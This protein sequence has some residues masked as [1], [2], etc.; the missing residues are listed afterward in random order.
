MDQDK[1]PSTT[2]N[3]NAM[4]SAS[5]NRV[6]RHILLVVIPLA[7]VAVAGYWYWHGGRFVETD[8]AYVK[9]DVIPISAEISA[10]IVDVLVKENQYVSAGDVLFELRSAPY[11]FAVDE[12]AANVQEKKTELL[13]LQAS[14]REKEGQI[15]LADRNYEFAQK[16]L[17]RQRD[18]KG[19]NFV[20]ES[21]LDDLEH[22]VEVARQELQVLRLDLQRIAASL[23]G[24]VDAPLDQHPSYLSA[25]AKLKQY[26]LSLS[27]T[28]VQAPVDGIVSQLPMVGQYVHTGNTVAALVATESLWVEANYSEVDLTHVRPGQKVDVKIDTYP[29]YHWQGVVESISPAT[30]AEFAILPAQNATGNWVKIAQRVPVRI[31]LTAQQGAP[32]LRSGL[33]AVVEID[34]EFRRQLFSKTAQ[35]VSPP[36]PDTQATGPLVKKQ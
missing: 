1:Q 19:K 2:T 12:A 18:L 34:T 4:N 16:E 29:D 31:A 30:G 15:M 9:A 10:S 11:Q 6:L 25:L 3:T 13:A 17:K 35:A 20:S 8:N 22:N 14:Y 27:R 23:G 7:V 26:Q 21:T 24:D 36:E 5:K 33:S 32:Q 28:K